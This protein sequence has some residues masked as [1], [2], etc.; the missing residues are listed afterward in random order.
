MLVPSFR[1]LA[2]TFF[3]NLSLLSSNS[4][5]VKPIDL[6]RLKGHK[7]ALFISGM[8]SI[9]SH[10]PT[11]SKSGFTCQQRFVPA[12]ERMGQYSTYIVRN[13]NTV[14]ASTTRFPPFKPPCAIGLGLRGGGNRE[15]IGAALSMSAESSPAVY[16]NIDPPA[17]AAQSPS[18][19]EL[20]ARFDSLRLRLEDQSGA[21]DNDTET[22]HRAGQLRREV[23]A[24]ATAAIAFYRSREAAAW[25]GLSSSSA[26]A[27]GGSS[28]YALSRVD[29]ARCAA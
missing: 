20:L 26:A 29:W 24:A 8:P 27:A 21:G 23:E 14:A 16:S 25:T 6:Q 11:F 28:G 2:T 17:A 3:L 22:E 15:G 19:A 18:E 13:F 12:L 5:E 7:A 10:F 4:R 1:C 9:F